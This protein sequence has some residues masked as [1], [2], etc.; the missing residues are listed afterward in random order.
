[1]NP[2]ETNQPADDNAAAYKKL[3]ELTLDYR[4][5]TYAGAE[6]RENYNAGV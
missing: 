2:N 1:M 4:R 6:A 5:A 3:V